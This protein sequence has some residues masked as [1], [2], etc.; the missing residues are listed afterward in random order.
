[1]SKLFYL[2]FFFVSIQLRCLYNQPTGVEKE[3]LT[4]CR[5]TQPIAVAKG[6]TKLSWAL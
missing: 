4:E 6:K 5:E 1:M 2:L 3:Q